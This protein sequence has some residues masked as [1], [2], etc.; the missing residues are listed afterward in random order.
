VSLCCLRAFV[1][2]CGVLMLL[3]ITLDDTMICVIMRSGGG[4]ISVYHDRM[5]VPEVWNVEM[6][7]TEFF[8]EL[9]LEVYVSYVYHCHPHPTWY[10][11]KP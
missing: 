5:A 11:L 9:G 8:A 2:V 4:W 10:V 7:V 3:S 6:A 1:S